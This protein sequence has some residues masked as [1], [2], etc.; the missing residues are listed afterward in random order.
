MVLLITIPF[1]NSISLGIYPTFSEKPKWQNSF[2]CGSRLKC[3]SDCQG[4]LAPSHCLH[5]VEA[6]PV[7]KASRC[8]QDR[9]RRS[10][11]RGRTCPWKPE[12]L[13][14]FQSTGP[15]GPG[16]WLSLAEFSTRNQVFFV[17]MFR[18]S[19]RFIGTMLGVSDSWSN[20]VGTATIS[21]QFPIG[22]IP[23]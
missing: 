15:K 6:A 18:F 1:L 16:N 22:K 23:W 5:F 14:E 3:F 4:S 20:G 13:Q 7:P 9:K 17:C 21:H 12:T 10:L 2:T 8:S 11:L 19:Q